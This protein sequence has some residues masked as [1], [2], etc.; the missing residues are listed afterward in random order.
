LSKFIFDREV[1]EK[2]TNDTDHLLV[3]KMKLLKSLLQK[4][5]H[6]FKVTIIVHLLVGQILALKLKILVAA[7]LQEAI[8]KKEMS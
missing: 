1:R 5:Y 3:G 7:E 2:S 4:L 8:G 6:G